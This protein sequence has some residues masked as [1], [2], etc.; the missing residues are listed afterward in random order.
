MSMINLHLIHHLVLILQKQVIGYVTLQY[1]NSCYSHDYKRFCNAL[2]HFPYNTQFFLK[3][4]DIYLARYIAHYMDWCIM[5]TI[6]VQYH[7]IPFGIS[8]SISD[9][10]MNNSTGVPYIYIMPGSPSTT[11]LEKNASSSFSFSEAMSDYCSRN[12]YD[13]EDPRCARLVLI[14]KVVPHLLA[15]QNLKT[16]KKIIHCLDI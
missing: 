4:P 10:P 12:L 9:G 1:W 13:P 3:S 2:F 6:S 11:D 8:V 5:S 15:H 7:G 14:G 16:T